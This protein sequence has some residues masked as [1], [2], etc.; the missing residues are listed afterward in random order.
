MADYKI[1]V[2]GQT[3]EADT[4]EEVAEIVAEILTKL[5][6]NELESEEK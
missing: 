2:L 4:E 3:I 5:F 1:L 6:V